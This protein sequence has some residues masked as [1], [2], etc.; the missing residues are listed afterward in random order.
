MLAG[1]WENLVSRQTTA[2]LPLRHMQEQYSGHWVT[3]SPGP[4][5]SSSHT[6][7]RPEQ[8]NIVRELPSSWENNVCRNSFPE[9]DA[10]LKFIEQ[11]LLLKFSFFCPHLKSL[12]LRLKNLS[13]ILCFLA[14]RLETF[15]ILNVRD[16]LTQRCITYHS[17]F[18]T[19][20]L[21]SE[22]WSYCLKK[23]MSLECQSELYYNLEENIFVKFTF[24]I[25]HIN[26]KWQ[27]NPHISYEFINM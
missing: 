21:S 4:R 16:D 27:M 22:G 8:K 17:V 13:S 11:S 6:V 3:G 26:L 24:N 5:H 10:T 25:S 7:T 15:L 19:N 9:N 12:P 20:H 1:I 14:S 23:I 2:S 18:T